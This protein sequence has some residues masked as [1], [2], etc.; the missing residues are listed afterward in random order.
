MI[1][2]ANHFWNWAGNPDSRELYLYGTIAEQSWFDDDVTPQMFRN[3]L[4]SGTGPVTVWLNSCGG[5][6]VAASQIYSM[7]IDYPHDVTVKIDGMAASAASVIAM[8]GTQVLMAPTASLMIHDPMTAAIGNAADMEKAIHMLESVKDS[9]IDAYELKTGLDRKTLAKMMTEETWMDCYK[10]VELGFADGIL[11]RESKP[12]ENHAKPVLFSQRAVDMA[13]VNR[14][15]S[16]AGVPTRVPVS[17]KTPVPAK[18][19]YDRLN[20]LKSSNN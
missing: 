11:E 4:M 16:S 8:A 19:L 18:P 15:A 7:L 17:A 9:I 12:I 10:A 13:L 5:D 2:S 1:E 6:C 20:R 3:E 14:L